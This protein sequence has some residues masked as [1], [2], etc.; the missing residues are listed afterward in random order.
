M[1]WTWW[2]TCR[3]QGHEETN[4]ISYQLGGLLQSHPVYIVTENCE[5]ILTI[6]FALVQFEL[7]LL[8]PLGL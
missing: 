4:T 6:G 5:S 3:V 2:E 1:T 7:T 8:V